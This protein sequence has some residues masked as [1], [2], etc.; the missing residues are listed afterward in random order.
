MR[1]LHGDIVAVGQ[2]VLT[3]EE[4]LTRSAARLQEYAREIRA[5]HT[6]GGRWQILNRADQRARDDHDD[7]LALAS[8]LLRMA[9]GTFEVKMEPT[10]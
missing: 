4:V 6:V 10:R 8:G 1:K 5:G 7:L 3:R 2:H 9:H